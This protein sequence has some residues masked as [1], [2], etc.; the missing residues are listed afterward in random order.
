MLA[1]DVYCVFPNHCSV[2]VFILLDS[3]VA[4][5][6]PSHWHFVFPCLCQSHSLLF[7]FWFI[8]Q[9]RVMISMFLLFILIMFIAR[10]LFITIHLAAQCRC[11]PG[12]SKD[13]NL[14]FKD[15]FYLLHSV[16]YYV[17]VNIIIHVFLCLRTSDNLTFSPSHSQHQILNISY[18]TMLII[19]PKCL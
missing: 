7:S 12:T 5:L 2:S 8:P 19:F 1:Q 11:K 14:M 3:T 10:R 13:H 4:Y 9:L 16:L 6:T 18:Y 15:N 17:F